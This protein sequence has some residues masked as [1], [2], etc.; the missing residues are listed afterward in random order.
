M[1]RQTDGQR[2]REPTGAGAAAGAAV[3]REREL[4][5]GFSKSRGWFLDLYGSGNDF[6]GKYMPFECFN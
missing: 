6:S 3:E 5:I 4:E 2:L 1:A